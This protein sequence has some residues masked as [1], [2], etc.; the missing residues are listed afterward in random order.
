MNRIRI[1]SYRLAA[2]A[3]V[4]LGAL[5]VVKPNNANW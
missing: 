4:A 5:R 1:A 3:V 2:L